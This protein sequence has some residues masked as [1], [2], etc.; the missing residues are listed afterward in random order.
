MI[1]IMLP[2]DIL[3]SCPT[4]TGQLLFKLRGRRPM[5]E[6]EDIYHVDKSTWSRVE[7]GKGLP[8]LSTL[9]NLHRYA[10]LSYEELLTAIEHDLPFIAPRGVK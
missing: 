9:I 3:E 1:L 4:L 6:M 7:R 5:R 10:S 8:N 2:S